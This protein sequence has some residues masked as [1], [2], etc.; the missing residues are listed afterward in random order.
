MNNN[1][2]QHCL[3]KVSEHKIE[4][5]EDGFVPSL[6]SMAN[7]NRRRRATFDGGEEKGLGTGMF[8][9]FCSSIFLSR[10]RMHKIKGS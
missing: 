3:F 8:A 2:T 1:Q 10:L 9:F 4:K 5:N 6:D 7:G